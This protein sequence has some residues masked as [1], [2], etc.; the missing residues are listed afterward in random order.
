MAAASHNPAVSERTDG[1]RAATALG[2]ANGPG[3]RIIPGSS[4]IRKVFWSHKIVSVLPVTQDFPI[5]LR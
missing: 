5:H 2:G 1:L 3:I 4:A